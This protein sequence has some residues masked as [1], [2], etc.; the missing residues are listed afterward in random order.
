MLKALEQSSVRAEK[1]PPEQKYLLE[2][3]ASLY[4][5]PQILHL[6]MCW[7][8]RER[9]AQSEVNSDPGKWS[10]HD[11]ILVIKEIVLRVHRQKIVTM[12]LDKLAKEE[13]WLSLW[14]L[15]YLMLNRVFRSL[16]Q[17]NS[18]EFTG[19]DQDNFI[20]FLYFKN[21]YNF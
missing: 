14:C 21:Y 3:T 15:N 13:Q 20:E 19:H 18:P 17:W 1:D 16:F 10:W 9:K 6:P 4:Q 11:E 7:K 12:I 8:M 2:N 5:Q